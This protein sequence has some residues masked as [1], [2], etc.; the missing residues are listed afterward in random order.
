MLEKH[1]LVPSQVGSFTSAQALRK[2]LLSK[3][4]GKPVKIPT[5]KQIQHWL[6]QKRAFTLHR[7]A[8][9]NYPMKKVC[10]V[11][12]YNYKQI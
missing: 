8:R 10:P 11:S 5:L 7:P 1:Y 9:K 6:M 12:T 3:K 4:R 2:S